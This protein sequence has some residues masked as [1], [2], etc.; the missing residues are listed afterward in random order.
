MARSLTL[1]DQ[2]RWTECR[3]ALSRAIFNE[4][5]PPARMPTHVLPGGGPTLLSRPRNGSAYFSVPR[6]RWYVPADE[7]LPD[8]DIERSRLC[9]LIWTIQT[10]S[11][12]LNATVLWTLNASSS[13]NCSHAAG[14]SVNQGRGSDTLIMFHH[15]HEETDC[16]P[17]QHGLAH[18][19]TSLGYDFMEFFMPPV[20]NTHTQARSLG[21]ALAKQGKWALTSPASLLLERLTRTHNWLLPLEQAGELPMKFFIEPLAL[22]AS[23]ASRALGYTRLVMMGLSG[24]G[25]AVT[26]AAALLPAVQLTIPVAGSIPNWPTLSYTRWAENLPSAYDHLKPMQ[27]KS[28]LRSGARMPNAGG[29][30]EQMRER[31]IFDAVG[32]Y[33]QL[34]ILGTLERHRYQLQVLHQ[35]DSCCFRA[36]GLHEFILDYNE[37]TQARI[38][39]WM[40]TVVTDSA[41]HAVNPDE[42]RLAAQ[43]IDQFHR[44]ALG[45]HQ[46]KAALPFDILNDSRL[47]ACVRAST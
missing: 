27:R 13:H 37:H 36:C 18:R 42:A 17:N 9:A 8:D 45:R 1:C 23:Y 25:W 7:Q 32:G 35:H 5:E 46:M 15:G 4:S 33:V 41:A 38:G 26:V 6:R 22:A 16:I 24:G 12:S 28:M 34:Y 3:I 19:F 39:G 40:R 2:G 43:V 20:C 10:G 11:L 21:R 47:L 14:S 29:D 31:P 30:F 44:G